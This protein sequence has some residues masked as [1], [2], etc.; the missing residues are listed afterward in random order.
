MLTLSDELFLLSLEDKKNGVGFSRS[1]ELPYAMAGAVL[2]E[3]SL[4]GKIRL[5][6]KRVI[7]LNATPTGSELLAS[8]AKRPNC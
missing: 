3:L 5:E 8:L 4:M 1:F 6:G 7:M 2:L